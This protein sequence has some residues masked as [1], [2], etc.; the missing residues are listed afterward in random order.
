MRRRKHNPHLPPCVYLRHG[1]YYHVKAGKWTRL[2]TDLPK[3]LS[4]YARLHDMRK[5]GMVQL[6]EDAL[7]HINR[8]VKESTADQY[9]IAAKKLQVIFEE[10]APHQ[11]KQSTVYAMQDG[12][13]STPNM[14]NRCLT[15][16]RLVFTYA[17]K[18]GIVEHNPC[19]GVDR[20]REKKRDRLIEHDEFSLVRQ[21]AAP[22]LQLMMDIAYLTGQR[23]MDVATIH[24]SAIREEGIYF[25]Q[26]KTEAKLLVAWTPELR[27]AVEKAKAL[28]GKVNAMTLFHTRHGT[29]PA[30][31]TV[32]DQWVSACK[33]AGI[34]DTDMRD[35]RAMS[36]TNAKRQGKDATALLGH[37][38]QAMTDRYLRDRDVPVV[39]GPAFGQSN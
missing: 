36:A 26:E 37:A 22:R 2:G 21:K 13:A 30:Y 15:V 24:R 9:K 33:R 7:P 18:R 35:I 16:L 38:S 23:I 19:T 14:A 10:F 31:R 34:G 29:A 5:G 27:Q 32:Y 39:H 25:K 1:A 17:A 20:L 4:E 11:V 8:E 6:I 3:A 28:G 12:L